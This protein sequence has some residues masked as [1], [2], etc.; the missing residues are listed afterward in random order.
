MDFGANSSSLTDRKLIRT[1]A[2]T[3]AIAYGAADPSQCVPSAQQ[4]TGRLLE[5]AMGF[6]SSGADYLRRLKRDQHPPGFP[7]PETRPPAEPATTGG[8][9]RRQSPRYKCAGSAQFRV[10]GSDIRT[11][12]TLTDISQHGCYVELMSTFPVGANV[13]LELELNGIRA[14][15]KGEVRVSYPCLGIGIAFREISDENRVRLLEM[16]RSLSPVAHPGTL[17]VSEAPS[18]S[19]SAS[20]PIIVNAGAALQALADFFETRA[21][22]TKEEFVRILRKSQGLDDFHDNRR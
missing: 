7:E 3:R 2:S 10:Q 16:M 17:A 21:Q 18:L 15:V 20:L 13:D 19:T 22:L 9:E 6:D 5:Y 4:G 11:W 1:A 14:D 8:S 12:G